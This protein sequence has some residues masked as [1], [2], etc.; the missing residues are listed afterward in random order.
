VINAKALLPRIHKSLRGQVDLPWWRA[1]W[2]VGS[3]FEEWP[4]AD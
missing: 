2:E 3:G 4:Q 1:G